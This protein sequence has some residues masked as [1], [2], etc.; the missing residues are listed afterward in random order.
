MYIFGQ[1]FG[2]SELHY[3]EA[4]LPEGKSHKAAY[5]MF[6]MDMAMAWVTRTTKG[7]ELKEGNVTSLFTI[8][9]KLHKTELTKA[10]GSYTSSYYNKDERIRRGTLGYACTSKQA[11][12]ILKAYK[13][14]GVYLIE[15]VETEVV[16]TPTFAPCPL[17]DDDD[18]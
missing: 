11:E 6:K 17:S 5:D 16:A 2:S 8:T 10:K 14:L 4:T 18:N 7:V 1:V 15:G 12:Q 9:D 3:D 13:D